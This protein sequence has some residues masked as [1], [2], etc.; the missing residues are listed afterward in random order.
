MRF[1]LPVV[2]GVSLVF[3]RKDL[4]ESFPT[5]WADYEAVLAANTNDTM[6]GFSF[7]GVTAQLVKLFLSRYWSQGDALMTPD[8]QP[9][10]NSEKGVMALTMLKDQ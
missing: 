9:L 4:I 2:S 7:A 10:I 3:Y 5:T 6:K 8:W 1:G